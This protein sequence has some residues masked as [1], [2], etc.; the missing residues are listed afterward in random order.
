MSVAVEITTPG[1]TALVNQSTVARPIQRQP[2]STAFLGGYAV[3]GPVGVPTVITSWLEFVRKFG[4]FDNNSYLADA[5]YA[6]FQHFG[7]AQAIISRAVG[8]TPVLGTKTLLDGAG[9]PVATLRVDAKYPSSVVDIK[10]KVETG[11]A[12]NSRKL[13]FSSVY[14]NVTEVFDNV[15]LANADLTDINQKSKLVNVV[16]LNSATVA[17]NNLPAVAAAASLTSNTD[18]VGN[19]TATQYVN[20]LNAFT[21]INLGG[22]QVAIPGLTASSVLVALKSHAETYKRLAILD[23]PFGNDV[24][25]MLGVDTTTY[26]SNSAALY[27]PWIKANKFDGSDATKYYPPS[28]AAL[29]A[30]AAVDR[31]EGV[32][33]APANIVVPFAI[34]VERN[35]DG[36][37]M[38]NDNARGSLAAKQINVIAPIANEG[39]K[40][41]DAQLLYPSGETRLKFV[42]ERR[43][44]NL[45]YFSAKL[46]YGWAV[47]QT[48][49]PQGRYF[50]DLRTSGKNFLRS[51]YNAGALYGKTE[52]EA[53]VVT[54]DESN[55][56]QEELALGRVHVAMGIKISPTAQMVIINID[57]VPLG[58]DLSVLNGGN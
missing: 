47:H 30:C 21:D 23:A 58:Q 55:N 12:A 6:F 5:V 10:V 46:G 13:T 22:G 28:I 3:W 56:P 42:H 50:R 14:L 20:S 24:S 45:V 57:N 18:D 41:Y 37:V 16:N 39:I 49:D 44:V 29:G 9:S 54:A 32:Q 2:S 25:T 43:V 38:L 11:T 48:V 4:G 31:N 19:I 53:F 27:Y 35:S 1:V 15:T 7:G 51:L 17:P 36:T 8:P 34:D 52:D 33:K 40:I 26:R